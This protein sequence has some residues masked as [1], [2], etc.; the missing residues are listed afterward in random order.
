MPIISDKHVINISF[1][2]VDS[3]SDN[4]ATMDVNAFLEDGVMK[5]RLKSGSKTITVGLEA[6]SEILAY[7]SDS[8]PSLS[9]SNSQ[10]AN[11]NS[12]SLKTNESSESGIDHG[13]VGSKGLESII[14]G[15]SSS[16]LN[17]GNE[18]QSNKPTYASSISIAS[19]A[20]AIFNGENSKTKS[21]LAD[22]LNNSVSK[23]DSMAEKSEIK[24]KKNAALNLE[25]LQNTD[26]DGR[27]VIDLD[28]SEEPS[29]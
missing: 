22:F 11:A 16:G 9:N 3:S 17:G 12:N 23:T 2:H 5:V 14:F 15:S 8:V 1:K 28:G 19:S 7:I 13:I 10:I 27:F 20:S 29:E 25:K 21:G 24:K 4:G 18:V 26:E 6:L